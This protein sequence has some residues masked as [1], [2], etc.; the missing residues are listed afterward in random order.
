MTKWQIKFDEIAK[1]ALSK[2][3]HQQ[4]SLIR[5]YLYILE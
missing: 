2:L 5:N 1:K 3:S 4:Q